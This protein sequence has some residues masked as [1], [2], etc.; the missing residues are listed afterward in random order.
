MTI[1]Q[2]KE[3]NKLGTMPC[4]WIGQ[5]YG[6]KLTEKEWNDLDNDEI[7]YIPEYGY[8]REEGKRF[9]ERADAYT[10]RDFIQLIR[11]CDDKFLDIGRQGQVDRMAKEL[12]EAVDWQYPESLLQEGFF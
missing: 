7:I 8:E 12:F 3:H 9:V 2:F 10:K 5:G 1:A 4:E 6:Y 11:N